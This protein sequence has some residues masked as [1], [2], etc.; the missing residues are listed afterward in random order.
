MKKI[1][2]NLYNELK[3]RGLLYQ[4]TN[5]EKLKFIQYN[6]VNSRA[7]ELLPPHEKDTFLRAWA[8]EILTIAP[9]HLYKYSVRMFKSTW[10]FF[11]NKIKRSRLACMQPCLQNHIVLP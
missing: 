11:S 10:E 1:N 6:Y 9:T 7:S 4:C 5:E 8:E 2:T 3:E